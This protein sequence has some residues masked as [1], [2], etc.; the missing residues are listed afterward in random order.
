MQGLFDVICILWTGFRKEL[1]TVLSKILANEEIRQLR[2]NELDIY[3]GSVCIYQLHDLGS[4]WNTV[5][6][7]GLAYCIRMSACL[8]MLGGVQPYLVCF[9]CT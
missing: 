8:F 2:T 6:T 5:Q 4:E 1:S 9:C 7:E 3:V